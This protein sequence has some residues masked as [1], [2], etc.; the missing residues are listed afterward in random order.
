[1]YV[2]LFD[3]YHTVFVWDNKTVKGVEHGIHYYAFFA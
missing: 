2:L 1:M 3:L